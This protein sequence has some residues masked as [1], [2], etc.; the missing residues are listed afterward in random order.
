METY[1]CHPP[2]SL[3]PLMSLLP[4][5]SRDFSLSKCLQACDPR[6]WMSHQGGTSAST[7]L[8]LKWPLEEQPPPAQGH[9]ATLRH[10]SFYT[11]KISMTLRGFDIWYSPVIW[12]QAWHIN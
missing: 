6:P 7:L 1:E 4:P 2:S 12:G 8:S 3:I 9:T 5:L 10:I 11:L